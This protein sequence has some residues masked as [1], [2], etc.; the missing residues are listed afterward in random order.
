MLY[1]N[2]QGTYLLERDEASQLRKLS[3]DTSFPLED[4]AGLRNVTLQQTQL[5]ALF[6]VN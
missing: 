2:A 6:I 3:V 1:P 5:A 4:T